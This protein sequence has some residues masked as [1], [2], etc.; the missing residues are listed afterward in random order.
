MSTP[1][2][3]DFCCNNATKYKI[4]AYFAFLMNSKRYFKSENLVLDNSMTSVLT[5][6]ISCCVVNGAS[7]L[8]G[9]TFSESSKYQE[10]LKFV[11]IENHKS[12]L[13]RIILSK[14]S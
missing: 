9:K 5:Y 11:P 8:I 6:R 14:S 12:D 3:V 2:T 1:S 4:F 7:C 13:Q 10:M